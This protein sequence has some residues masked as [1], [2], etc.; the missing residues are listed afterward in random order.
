MES[1]FD[2]ILHPSENDDINS[3][4]KKINNIVF[5][6]SRINIIMNDDCI[7]LR[8]DE[9]I[10]M[11]FVLSLIAENKELIEML[12]RNY[13]V[14]QITGFEK[15][16]FNNV[17]YEIHFDLIELLYLLKVNLNFTYSMNKS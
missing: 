2:L 1:L 7:I 10:K 6:K 8:T 5:D 3:I 12:N 16:F 13:S 9:Y 17:N 11:R 14:L 15:D 4:N